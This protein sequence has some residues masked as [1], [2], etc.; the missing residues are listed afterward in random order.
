MKNKKIKRRNYS[1]N[2]IHKLIRLNKEYTA[3]K[4]KLT[5]KTTS[6]IHLS[7]FDK[8]THLASVDKSGKIS[9]VVN[10]SYEILLEDI[11]ITIVRFDSHHGYLHRHTRISLEDKT[12]VEDTVGVKKRG[13]PDLWY[14]WAIQNITRNFLSYRG[15]FVKRS[16]ILNLGY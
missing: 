1:I 8:I 7:D 15:S 3:R 6:E 14:T 11:W 16:K 10:V 4:V 13:T 12:E 9:E 5:L 2:L